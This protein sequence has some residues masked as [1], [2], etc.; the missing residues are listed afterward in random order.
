MD[1]VLE[2]RPADTDSLQQTGAAHHSDKSI[3]KNEHKQA[4]RFPGMM[5]ELQKGGVRPQGCQ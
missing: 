2:T 1:E 4:R 5:E 3:R